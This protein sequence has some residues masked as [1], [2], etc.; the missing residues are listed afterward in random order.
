MDDALRVRAFD[1]RA[2]SQP[3]DPFRH[4]FSHYHLDIVPL[5]VAV[6]PAGTRDS[7]GRWVDPQSPGTLGLAAPV[8]K[9][10][11]GLDAPRQSRML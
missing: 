3:L 11:A 9:L 4:T 5:E 6:D 2:D 1:A 8:K 7:D 10:L